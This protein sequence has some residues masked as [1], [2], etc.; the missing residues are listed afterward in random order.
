M[1]FSIVAAV[2][3]NLGIGK[4]NSLPWRLPGD[5]KY[6]SEVTRT[7]DEGMLNA[8]IMGRKT[9]ESLPSD[10]KPLKGRINIVLSRGKVRLPENVILASS[11][12]DAFEKLEKVENLN[13]IFII[14]GVS[15]YNQAIELPDCQKL[16]ITE[17]LGD[18]DCDAFFPK[19]SEEEFSLVS[20]SHD[21]EENGLK[22]RFSVYEN[23]ELL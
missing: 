3:K 6:F 16:F 10:S 19:F 14:G 12:D 8:V 17:V 15:I 22:Y 4:D 2:D 9:W 21:H 23:V 5:L 13:N 7:A 18:F 11:L 20:R 1:K